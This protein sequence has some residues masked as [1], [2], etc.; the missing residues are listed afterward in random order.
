M[1][2]LPA[3]DLREHFSAAIAALDAADG[4]EYLRPPRQRL[5]VA[6]FDAVMVGAMRRVA[7]GKPIDEQVVRHALDVLKADPEFDRAT[8]TQADTE[9]NVRTRLR[10]ATAVFTQ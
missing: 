8:S 10:I 6:T 7:T 5:N 2:K 3:D 1:D 9:D 4:R